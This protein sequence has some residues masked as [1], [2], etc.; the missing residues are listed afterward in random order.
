MSSIQDWI[1]LSLVPGLG[2]NGYWRLL[3]YFHSPGDVLQASRKQESSKT[4]DLKLK[5]SHSSHQIRMSGGIYVLL[6]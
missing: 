5:V 6:H 3:D 2:I 1:S 4:L